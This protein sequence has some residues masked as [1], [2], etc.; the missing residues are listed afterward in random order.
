MSAF[1]N[2]PTAPDHPIAGILLCM[3]GLFLFSI[4]DVLIKSLSDDYSVLQ[5]VVIRGIVAVLPILLFILIKIGARG[6]R[7]GKPKLLFLRG[8]LSFCAYLTYYLALA[9]L[10][11]VEVV[12]I[13]FSAPIM[14]T[15]LSAV[16]LKEPVG[17]HRWTMIGIGFIAI[18]IVVGPSGDFRHLATILALVAAL[19]YACQ[20]LVTRLI[21]G[22]ENPW[23]VTLYSMLSFII[24]GTLAGG[25]IAAL[26]AFGLLAALGDG[27]ASMQ[28]LLRPWVL[29]PLRDL[30]VMIFIGVNGAVAFYCL[31]K[32]YWSAPVSVVAPFEYTYII[33]AAILGYL[34]WGEIPPAHGL[35][36]VALLIACGVY[37]F[38]RE[39]QLAKIAAAQPQPEAIQTGWYQ[40][41]KARHYARG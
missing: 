1:R 28:F 41:L 4:Q 27:G 19:A 6:L 23:T 25:L 21:G 20:N 3:A 33:W 10:P 17:V 5:I 8:V 39:A 32:A 12:T 18:I 11:L 38:H 13:V 40:H 16:I 29:P 26:G 31:V 7:T 36:G 2:S 35:V 9:A 30:L 24:G 34:I 15:V 37:I 22:G 14:V